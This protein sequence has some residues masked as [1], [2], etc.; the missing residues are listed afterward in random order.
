M[1]PD[2]FKTA[3]KI[4]LKLPLTFGANFICKCGY[5]C[6]DESDTHPLR[7]PRNGSNHA[8]HNRALQFIKFSR[9]GC[10]FPCPQNGCVSALT[11]SFSLLTRTTPKNFSLTL[12][13]ATH[14]SFLLAASSKFLFD[15]VFAAD[16][17]THDECKVYA[18]HQPLLCHLHTHWIHWLFQ[19]GTPRFV[20]PIH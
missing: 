8:C 3:F 18:C 6:R 9:N 16:I 19:Q 14:P 1:N 15:N 2:R 7:C 13:V 5:K 11:T 4:R 10:R 17:T 12:L 20:R